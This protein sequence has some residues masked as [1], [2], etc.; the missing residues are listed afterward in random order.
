MAVFICW[1]GTRSHRIALAVKDLL[2]STV[3][4]LQDRQSVF[5]S[6]S[7]AKGVAW[8]DSILTELNRAKVGIACVTAEN[9]HSPWM[10]FEAGALARGLSALPAVAAPAPDA[11]PG[12]ANGP[13]S[14]PRADNNAGK[15]PHGAHRSRL[16]TV[17]HGTTSAELDGPLSAYQATGTTRRE[18]AELV[19]A[20]RLT[21][22]DPD[23]DD[24]NLISDE[25]WKVFERRLRHVRV[26]ARE[27]VPELGRLFQRKTFYE[28]IQQCADQAW[29]ARYEGARI[30]RETLRPHF[31]RVQSACPDHERGM[32]DMLLAELDAY[33]M[34]IQ[35]LF[36]TPREFRLGPSGELDIEP[37]IRTCCED[38]RLAIQSLA[39]RLLHPLD[40]PMLPESVWFMAAG[41]DEE[42]K[43]II[44]R[45]EAEVR[46]EREETY[47]DVCKGSH[48]Q[49]RIDAALDR[50]SRKYLELAIERDTVAAA[51]QR[52]DEG[53]DTLPGPDGAA[54]ARVPAAVP[55]EAAT[56]GPSQEPP[57]RLLRFRESHWDLDRIYYYLL[58]QYFGVDALRWEL[59]RRTDQAADGDERPVLKH[60][61]EC[62]ARDVEMEIDWYR[63]RAKGGSL[64]PLTYALVALRTLKP[65]RAASVE[66]VRTAVTAAVS[67]V[68]EEFADHLRTEQ[69]RPIAR[70]LAEIW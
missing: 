62:A 61:L 57:T 5:V 49:T 12:P 63:S 68:K 34:S 21:L 65:S 52:G 46:R 69:G 60:D 64:T 37:G 40:A 56:N 33:A 27:L 24:R 41:T 25:H 43:L 32:V 11:G 10:H 47:E 19:R 8:F 51:D 36:L 20:L 38:R 31:E 70:L 22:G 50:L 42:R 1:S 30:T 39:G 6:D 23:A 59:D 18:M 2:E 67:L 4:P 28:P 15:A 55:P 45:L 26:P 29:L 35:A 13:T 3:E 14:G 66:S 44:H 9:L 7:I 16:F 54:E 48:H 53:P 17:L 58:V